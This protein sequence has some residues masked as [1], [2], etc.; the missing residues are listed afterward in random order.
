MAERDRVPLWARVALPAVV[1]AAALVVGSGVFDSSPPT[2]AQ[3]AAALDALV[4]CPS[5]TDISVAQSHE[6]T[7]IAVRHEIQNLLARGKSDA[8]VKSVLVSQYGPS[9]LL[10]PPDTAGIPVIWVVP[11]VLA[12]GALGAVGTLF[13]RRSRQFARLQRAH[14]QVGATRP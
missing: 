6:T 11:A 4:R 1:V 14:D 5:C 2:L 12:L 9:I 3:R 13:W 7:A 10:E 8:Q